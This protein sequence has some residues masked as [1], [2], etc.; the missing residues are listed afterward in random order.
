[1]ILHEFSLMEYENYLVFCN[2]NFQKIIFAEP[3]TM[4]VF[5]PVLEIAHVRGE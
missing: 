3:E 2:V 5:R 1:M 4:L